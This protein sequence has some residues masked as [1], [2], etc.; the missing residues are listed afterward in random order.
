M[1]PSPT[2]PLTGS[3]CSSA[4]ELL[5]KAGPMG[6]GAAAPE[7]A[8]FDGETSVH[9]RLDERSH[10]LIGHCIRTDSA[11]PSDMGVPLLCEI[12]H[13]QPGVE[14]LT[15]CEAKDEWRY[16]RVSKVTVH[17]SCRVYSMSYHFERLASWWN[18][19]LTAHQCFR[20]PGRGWVRARDLQAGDAFL[21]PDGSRAVF[22]SLDAFE[23]RQT[24]Y[25]L[26]V[27]DVGTYC[28]GDGLLVR[29]R[30]EST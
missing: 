13:L 17:E 14:V 12:W 23:Y 20:V 6:G 11:R 29:S 21:T 25:H 3:W 10:Q 28:V 4:S 24:V 9:I 27:E 30:T 7:V 22:G 15:W 1:S 2:R 8:G 16:R 5:S 18:L 26:E 19:L